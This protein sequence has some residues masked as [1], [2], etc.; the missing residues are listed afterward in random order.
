MAQDHWDLGVWNRIPVTM[1]WTV[2]FNFVWLALMFMWSPVML[3]AAAAAFFALLVAHEFG[4]VFVLRRR[5]IPISGITLNGFHGQTAY[6]YANARDTALIAWGGV[7]AQLIILV[8]ACAGTFLL[9]GVEVPLY[10]Q[11]VLSPVTF[12][13][14]WINIVLIVIAL[15]PIGPFDGHDAWS[16]IPLIRASMRKRFRRTKEP[17][18]TPEQQRELEA[19]SHAETADLLDRLTRKSDKEDAS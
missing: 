12:V 3:I 2:L 4:H 1:H 16:A 18:L 17:K 13:F 10:A 8:A 14:T 5:K 9:R 11:Y 15:L 6:A 7:F 19:K